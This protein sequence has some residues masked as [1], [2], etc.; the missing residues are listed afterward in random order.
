MGDYLEAENYGRWTTYKIKHKVA[1]SDRKVATSGEKVATSGENLA[2]SGGNLAS[3]GGNL[4]S[5]TELPKRISIEKME[6]IIMR[7]CKD[8]YVKKEDLAT[9]LNRSENYIRNEILPKMIKEKKIE[10]KYPFTLNHPEQAYKT[11][12][13][14]AEKL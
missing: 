13:E 6:D 1:S 11:T 5:L 4:A 9:L 2:S 14:Y 12:E 8:N 10:K 3:S 7:I